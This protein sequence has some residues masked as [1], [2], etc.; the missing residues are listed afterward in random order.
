MLL[1][2]GGRKFPDV[3]F[4]PGNIC[5]MAGEGAKAY[6]ERQYQQMRNNDRIRAIGA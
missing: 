1:N 4:I 6:A 2:S 3:E 5:Y